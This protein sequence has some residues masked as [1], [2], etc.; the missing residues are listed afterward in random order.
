MAESLSAKDEL[1]AAPDCFLLLT[2]VAIF[3]TTLSVTERLGLPWLGTSDHACL[4][5]HDVGFEMQNRRRGLWHQQPPKNIRQNQSRDPV[6]QRH[7]QP[8]KLGAS[9]ESKL[10]TRCDG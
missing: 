10:S 9:G 5:S 6:R 8:L 2:G 1:A 7:D 3:R 4:I